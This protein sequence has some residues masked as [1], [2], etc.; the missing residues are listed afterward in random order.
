MRDNTLINMHMFEAARINGVQKFLFTSS[1]CIY[2]MCRQETPDVTPLK[3]EDAYPAD[4][5]DGYGW[6]KLFT[7]RQC[8][9]TTKAPGG[10]GMEQRQYALA[11]GPWM[12]AES[13]AGRG[14]GE[15]LPVDSRRSWLPAAEPPAPWCGRGA[16]GRRCR[17]VSPL[18][19]QRTA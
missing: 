9:D 4:A 8:R 11:A 2:P 17:R 15:D 16:S 6:E 5:E 7:E 14:A 1:A 19:E 3:D 13:S 18:R 10:A 12:G